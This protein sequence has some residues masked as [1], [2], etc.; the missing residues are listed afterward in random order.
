VIFL[1]GPRVLPHRFTSNHYRDSFLH[2]LPKLLEDAPLS[3]RA[4]M[5][6]LHDGAPPHL[7]C[8]VLDVLSN[9]CHVRWIGRGGPNAWPPR[10]TPDLILLDFYLWGI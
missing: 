6:Y 10:S 3:V 4:R 5:W 8:A 9:T 7:S 1:V 2:D